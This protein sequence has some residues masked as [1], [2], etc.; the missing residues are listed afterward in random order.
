MPKRSSEFELFAPK[1]RPY[2]ASAA[3]LMLRGPRIRAV[4]RGADLRRLL[5]TTID[6][7]TNL[8]VRV[9]ELEAELRTRSGDLT[10]LRREL[11]GAVRDAMTDPLTGLAN[12]RSFDLKLA[13]V[14]ARASS[15]PRDGRCRSLQAAQRRPRAH[16][17]R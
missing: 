11:L 12:R 13:A 3:D 6:E 5:R 17:R 7:N 2:E 9:R 16:H 8:T 10:K 1:E 14:A 4:A 15:A